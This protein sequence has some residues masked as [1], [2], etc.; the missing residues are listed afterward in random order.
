MGPAP[1]GIVAGALFLLLGGTVLNTANQLSH[2]LHHLE[3]KTVRVEVR[4]MPLPASD[5]GVF[6]IDSIVAFGEA[7][8]IHLRPASG[9][10]RTLLK[11]VSLLR[12]KW[13]ETRSR[14]PLLVT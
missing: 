4:G 11:V 2:S 6:V 14:S 7:L 8:L 10:P 12:R 13:N 3:K 5:G 9:G 1:L